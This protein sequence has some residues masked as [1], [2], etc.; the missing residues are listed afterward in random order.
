L[1][2]TEVLEQSAEASIC[3]ASV[4]ADSPFARGASFP[5][6][7]ALEMGAQ[8]AAAAEL[9]ARAG[10]GRSAV[11]PRA[12]YVVGADRT[13]L[14]R[15]RLPLDD[16][17]EVRTRLLRAAPPLRVW[18]IEVLRARAGERLATAEVSTFAV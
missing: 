16:E 2:V 7:L 1:L 15:A 11:E 18:Q 3:L 8:A 6:F 13:E 17:Y 12:G 4:P 5:A 10:E 9:L 14:A